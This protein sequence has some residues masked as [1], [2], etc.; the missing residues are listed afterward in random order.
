MHACRV[1]TNIDINTNLKV[2]PQCIV[3]RLVKEISGQVYFRKAIRRLLI[4]I[5]ES[6]VWVSFIFV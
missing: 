3:K 1:Y 6:R 5:N 4:F 2:N